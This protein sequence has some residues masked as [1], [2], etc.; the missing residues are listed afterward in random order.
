LQRISLNSVLVLGGHVS[1]SK[2]R[3]KAGPWGVAF[4]DGTDRI[5]M[6]VFNRSRRI[7]AT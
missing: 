6:A 1:E 2:V 3:V 7:E 4:L 5:D